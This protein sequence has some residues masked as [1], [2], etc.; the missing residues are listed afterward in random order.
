MSSPVVTQKSKTS[1]YR[2]L[3]GL[4]LV[5]LWLLLWAAFMPLDEGVAAAARVSLD[6]QRKIVQHARGGIVTEVMVREGQ[7]VDAGQ[8]LIRLDAVSTEAELTAA[9]QRLHALQAA[10]GRLRAEQLQSDDLVLPAATA[11]TDSVT[12][13]P[14]RLAQQALLRARRQALE[15]D[16]RSL[17]QT[18]D[19]QIALASSSK[20]RLA[21]R[22]AQHAILQEE[23]DKLKDLV[24]Q[25]YVPRARQWQ[26]QAQLAEVQA[27]LAQ[28]RGEIDRAASTQLELLERIEARQALHQRAIATELAQVLR[29]LDAEQA[30]VEALAD[31]LARTVIRAPV[32]GQVLGLSFQTVGGVIPPGQRVLEI[33]PLD[34]PLLIDARI[35]PERIDSVQTGLTVDV[36]YTAFAGQPQRT[37]PGVVSS[38]SQDALTDPETGQ[39]YYLARVA[40]TPDAWAALG[41]QR[42]QPGMPAEVVILTG[43]RSLLAYLIQPLTRRMASAL[44]EP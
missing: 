10:L 23:L 41:E 35:P 37:L 7:L 9:T 30:R 43:E 42:L 26:L 40:H 29:E 5:T 11:A 19:I 14:H 3:T 16:L 36:R 31:E 34:E 44:T 4:S 15:A 6:T 27:Q 8:V 39:T 13:E 22:Q 25:A 32:N 38:V 12:F 20:Q 24:E 21:S 17:R 2:M 33:V 1:S 18:I 28:D